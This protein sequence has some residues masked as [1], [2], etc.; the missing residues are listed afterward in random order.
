[1]SSVVDEVF[2]MPDDPRV[3]EELMAGLTEREAK[4]IEEGV[5]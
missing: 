4:A 5:N 3:V 1:M 2:E